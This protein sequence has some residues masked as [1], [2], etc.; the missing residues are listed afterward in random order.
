MRSCAD[1]ILALLAVASGPPADG[2]AMPAG[3]A[4]RV[5]AD[6]AAVWSVPAS[7]VRLEWGRGVPA[8]V[9][10]ATPY[11]L[12]GRGTDGWFVVVFE[13][14][15]GAAAVRLHAGTMDTVQV[16][17]RAL[18]VGSRLAS[19]DL[20]ASARLRWGPPV[21]RS[22]TP[23]PGWQVRRPIAVGE[24]L[25]RPAVAPPLLVAAGSAVRLLWER[26]GVQIALDGIALNDAR[27]GETVRARVEGRGR[28]AAGTVIAP[29]TA[30]LSNGGTR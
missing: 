21:T 10:E 7:A 29:G 23:G 2:P 5:S 24:A 8:T 30:A 17:T 3:L 26:G 28:Y 14:A 27:Q 12:A 25:S 20:E 19:T 4:A 15:G 22:E 16:A 6:V 18:P 1:L 9:L 13:P 11:R